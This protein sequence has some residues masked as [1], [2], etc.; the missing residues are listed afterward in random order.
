MIEILVK[1][2]IVAV[3]AIVFVASFRDEWR[4][5]RAR[6]DEYD[7]FEQRRAD[8]QDEFDQ[9]AVEVAHWMLMQDAAQ[10]HFVGEARHDR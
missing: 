9:H 3:A 10:I 2:I 1:I 7:A 6:E 5:L 8:R 4:R